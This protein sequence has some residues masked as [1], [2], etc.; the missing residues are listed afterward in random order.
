MN[1]QE[2]NNIPA[3]WA[4]VLPTEEQ[5]EYA[6]RAGTNTAY[7]WGDSITLQ[8]ANY[9]DDTL[10]YWDQSTKDVGQYLPNAWGFYDMHGNVIEWTNG[11]SMVG[12]EQDPSLFEP[13]EQRIYRGGAFNSGK[14]SLRSAYRF[15]QYPS[16]TGHQIGFR[17]AYKFIKGSNLYGEIGDGTN[18]SKPEPFLIIEKGVVAVDIG[19]AA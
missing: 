18:E 6:C 17:L 16:V 1:E 14:L 12:P 3:G 15:D 10:S 5:W 19:Q 11:L 13:V 2:K 9:Y 4:Y 7:S 8:N